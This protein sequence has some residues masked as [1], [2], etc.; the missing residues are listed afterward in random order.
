MFQTLLSTLCLRKTYTIITDQETSPLPLANMEVYLWH[1]SVLLENHANTE[2][3]NQAGTTAEELAASLGYN[4][5]M[6]T[7]AF[8]KKVSSW[9]SWVKIFDGDSITLLR[10]I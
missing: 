9:V 3:K 8:Y 7:I 4:D 6:E 2:L 10:V 1:P 5:I